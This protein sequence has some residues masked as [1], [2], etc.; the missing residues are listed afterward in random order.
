VGRFRDELADASVEVGR[1]ELD[2]SFGIEANMD[3]RLVVPSLTIEQYQ[4]ELIES[5]GVPRGAEVT[6]GM[7]DRLGRALRAEHDSLVAQYRE[8]DEAR[9]RRD[10]RRLRRWSTIGGAVGF[11]A[12]VIS[13]LL[14]YLGISAREVNSK[15]SF[16]SLRHYW[17]EYLFLIGIVSL[18]ATGGWL[19]ELYHQG[20]TREQQ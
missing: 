19:Y 16:L 14:A 9:F 6:G 20:K 5:L 7:V 11:V 15:Y 10:E 12:V 18:A 2:L 8:A 3:A 13:L 4:R 17:P 1:L